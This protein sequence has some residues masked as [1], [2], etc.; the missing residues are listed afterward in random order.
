MGTVVFWVQLLGGLAVAGALYILFTI[1]R[2][3]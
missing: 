3:P 2:R 1:D